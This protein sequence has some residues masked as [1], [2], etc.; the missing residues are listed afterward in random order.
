MFHAARTYDGSINFPFTPS[1]VNNLT[2][3]SLVI[4]D[5]LGQIV[6]VGSHLSDQI[7][8]KIPPI[9]HPPSHPLPNNV[10]RCHDASP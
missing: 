5:T 9:F 7:R 3:H 4:Q 8:T 6:G 10:L 2:N 1:T